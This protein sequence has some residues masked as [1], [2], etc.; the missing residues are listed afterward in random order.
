MEFIL[1]A[2]V[3]SEEAVLL[4]YSGGI[5]VWNCGVVKSV[6]K[7]KTVVVGV[8]GGIAAYKLLDMVRALKKRGVNVVVIMTSHAAAMVSPS[9]FKKA[10]GTKVYVRL[11]E[12]GF[13][14]RKIL[15]SREV[16]HVKIAKE[17]NIFIIAPA[18]AN[19]IAKLA[20]GI[21]DDFLTT[22]ALATTAPVLIFPSMNT[23]MWEH[24][25]VKHNVSKIKKAG[26]HVFEPDSGVLACGDEGYGRLPNVD[27][28]EKEILSFLDGYRR[29]EGLRV[30]VTAGGTTEPID[31]VRSITNRSS[32]KMGAAIADACHER[33]AHVTLFKAKNATLPRSSVVVQEFSTAESLSRLV[34]ASRSR[35]DII[36]HTAAVAD[37][38]VKNSSKK[39]RPSDRAFSISLAPRKKLYRLFGKL[40]PKATLV[41]FKAED[42]TKERSLIASG[43]RKLEESGCDAVIVNGISKTNTGFDSEYNAVAIVSRHGTKK[44]RRARKKEIADSLVD[45]VGNLLLPPSTK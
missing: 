19:V 14:H 16:D 35:F 30:L 22:T 15:R 45:Y 8:T 3:R 27:A 6:Q 31:T 42:S 5:H 1:H 36:Y 4:G 25:I 44:L 29:F 24:P 33:G 39:K 37:F 12:D 17:A 10:S 9:L 18:T 21:A 20:H 13:D 34:K 26:Y 23:R 28:M 43:K 38:T 40:Y 32:G 41:L 2:S 7:K 11:F